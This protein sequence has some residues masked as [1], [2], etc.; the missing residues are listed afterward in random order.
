MRTLR[1][2]LVGPVILVLMLG[3]VP[4]VV[5]Q[6]DDMQSPATATGTL[7]FLEP[8]VEDE[9]TSLDEAVEHV[10]QWTSSDPR[11]SGTATY[12]GAWHLYDPPAE[13][14]DDPEATAGAVYEIV[15]EGGSWLC[16]GVRA[17]IPG[18]S[19]AT[20]VHT[21]VLRGAGG[22]EGLS[23]YIIVD[24]SVSPFAFSALITP[25]SVPLVP[26]RPG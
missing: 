1:A 17:P 24:W 8:M 21:I 14:C 22:Y 9:G 3:L 15:N 12:T 10:H 25:N 13:D 26:V 11:L 7:E 20:N 19:G 6:T 2:L 5:A 23:A 4:P 16:A 18:P